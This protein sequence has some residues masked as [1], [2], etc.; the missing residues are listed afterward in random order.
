MKEKEKKKEKEKENLK[1]RSKC[2]VCKIYHFDVK[3]WVQHSELRSKNKENDG[4]KKMNKEKKKKKN[5][6]KKRKDDKNVKASHVQTFH[7]VR[8]DFNFDFDDF[9][10]TLNS[11]SNDSHVY[12][13]NIYIDKKA[14]QKIVAVVTTNSIEN[15]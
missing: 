14:A 6:K 11:D 2:F 12:F 1:K 15:D 9:E 10:V 5:K 3:Y 7:V 4:K 8:S 13:Y